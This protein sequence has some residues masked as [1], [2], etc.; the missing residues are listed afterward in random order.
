MIAPQEL[1]DTSIEQIRTLTAFL[2][3]QLPEGGGGS[4][5]E[6]PESRACNEA[7]AYLTVLVL[8]LEA[9]TIHATERP[10]ERAY[11]RSVPFPPGAKS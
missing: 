10:R 11:V 7:L 2:H 4:E 8:R 6:T 3:E 5:S 1:L 9:S